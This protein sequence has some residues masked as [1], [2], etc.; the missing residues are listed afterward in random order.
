MISALEW[1]F[2]ALLGLA[3]LRLGTGDR[4]RGRKLIQHGLS[5]TVWLLSLSAVGSVLGIVSI[6]YAILRTGDSEVS[7]TG[8]RLGGLLQYPNTFG[9]VAAA[10]LLERLLL[11]V[12]RPCSDRNNFV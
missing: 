8:A 1:L 7:L 5:W 12:S 9:A 10:L 11:L 4:E 2:Y 6:P 3:M